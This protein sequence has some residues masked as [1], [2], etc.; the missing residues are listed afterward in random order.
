MNRI[1][2]IDTPACLEDVD[3]TPSKLP[4]DDDG[5]I[6]TCRCL[7]VN[8]HNANNRGGGSRAALL[9]VKCAVVMVKDGEV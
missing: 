4:N 7:S 8:N 9:H 1:A 2:R 3:I 5:S 6:Q